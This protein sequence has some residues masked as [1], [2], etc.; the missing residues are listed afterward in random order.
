MLREFLRDRPVNSCLFSPADAEAERLTALHSG[1]RTPLSY[2]NRP[3]TNRQVDPR[4][5]PGEGYTV[6]TYRQAIWR[7]CDQA[8]PPPTHLVRGRVPGQ[9]GDRTETAAE[10]K[11]RLGPER[12]KELHAWRVAR[13]WHPHQLRHNAATYIRKEFGIEVARVILGHRTA[14]VTE[15]YA[16]LDDAKAKTAMQR[17]G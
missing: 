9:R 15:I 10:W 7:A 2:G 1:R 13:R 17:I 4:R 8:F 14:A 5:K 3:G 11:A 6:G 16:E 12:Q